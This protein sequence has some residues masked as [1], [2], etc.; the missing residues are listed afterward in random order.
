M[1][2]IFAVLSDIPF[3]LA[4]LFSKRKEAYERFADMTVEN[5]RSPEETADNVIKALKKLD[6]SNS[7]HPK[8]EN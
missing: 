8:K 5:D 3:V 2:S 4:E 6:F 1:L 7:N